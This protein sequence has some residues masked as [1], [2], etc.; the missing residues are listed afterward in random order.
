MIKAIFW[1]G[2][3]A[4]GLYLYNDPSQMSVVVDMGKDLVNQGAEFIQDKTKAE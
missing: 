1:M 4:L 2:I 3:G